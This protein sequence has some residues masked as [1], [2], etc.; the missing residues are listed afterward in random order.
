MNLPPTTHTMSGP[1][2]TR[3]LGITLGVRALLG[4][5]PGADLAP[6]NDCSMMASFNEISR[7][8]RQLKDLGVQTVVDRGGMTLGRDLRLYEVLT[9]HTGVH[10]VGSTG[11]G[12]EQ[13]VGS[14][15]THPTS[16]HLKPALPLQPEELATLFEAEVLDGMV[17]PRVRRAARAGVISVAAAENGI[18]EFEE[19]SFR[20]A[21]RTAARTGASVIARTGIDPVRELQALTCESLS[22]SRILLT[23]MD[24]RAV[25]FDVLIEVLSSGASVSFDN[26]GRVPTD[27]YPDD[28]K[29]IE[30][31]LELAAA[32][33]AE[34]LVLGSEGYGRNVALPD[35]P[36]AIHHILT[37]FV[38]AL[39]A[40]G[41]DEGLVNALLANNSQRLL[42]LDTATPRSGEEAK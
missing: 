36:V 5:L 23:N 9:R 3:E 16:M 42:A 18:T 28:S 30:L 40:A 13:H 14:H 29:R 22:A 17:V 4:I 41:A 7:I 1:V 19:K 25:S 10:I 34:R 33:H 26:V 15:F 6:E 32:G 39:R 24:R 21:A 35:F 12:Q 31:I 11:M 20:A 8:L 37:D 2:P 38:P 27:R